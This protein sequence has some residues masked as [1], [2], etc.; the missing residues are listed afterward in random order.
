MD[1]ICTGLFDPPEVEAGGTLKGHVSL[2]DDT[3]AVRDAQVMRL[4]AICRIEGPGQP[5]ARILAQTELPG[6]FRPRANV[7]FKL[8][9]P[10]EALITYQGIILRIGWHLRVQFV[11]PGSGDPKRELPFTVVPARS[12]TGRTRVA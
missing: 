9:L 11:A 10:K 6:P 12:S 1:L 4:Q 7:P 8:A 5:E 2:L 3:A